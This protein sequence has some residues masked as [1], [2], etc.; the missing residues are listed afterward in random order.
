MLLQDKKICW[1]STS[2]GH[3][4]DIILTVFVSSLIEYY[5]RS[6]SLD[7]IAKLQ[8]WTQRKQQK[9]FRHCDWYE[10]FWI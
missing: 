1:I 2:C 7:A 5:L 4:G 6:K 3:L 10:Q 9:L 8:A